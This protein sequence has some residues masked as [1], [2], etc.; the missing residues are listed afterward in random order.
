MG[1]FNMRRSA[2][3]VLG[4]SAVALLANPGVAGATITGSGAVTVNGSKFTTVIT[5]L[6][7]DLPLLRCEGIAFDASKTDYNPA[8]DTDPNVK[9]YEGSPAQVGG[10]YAIT[11]PTL[12]AGQVIAN[13]SG[14][15]TSADYPAGTYWVRTQC[16]EGSEAGSYQ[17]P[18]T[19]VK[20]TVTANA[21][22]PSGTPGGAFGGLGTGSA[23]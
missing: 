14:T 5:S 13:G 4:I 22:N 23:A 7:T 3:V 9:L 2:A 8:V 21:Q 6:K 12:V 18:F 17:T 20:L 16:K 11:G 10:E 15:G 19:P 1:T